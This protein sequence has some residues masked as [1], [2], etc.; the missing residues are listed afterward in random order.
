[1]ELVL[2]KELVE[3]VT[4]KKNRAPDVS[5]LCCIYTTPTGTEMH[6]VKP[7]ILGTFTLWVRGFTSI[8]VHLQFVRVFNFI[9]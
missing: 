7:L 9:V 3:K 8:F 6:I 4:K 2:G 5:T 1:M